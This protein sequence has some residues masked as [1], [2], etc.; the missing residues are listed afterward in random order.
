[1]SLVRW[2]ILRA[3]TSK[4]AQVARD[5]NDQGYRTHLAWT[6]ARKQI[7]HHVITEARLRLSPYVFVAVDHER[8][9]FTPVRDT[10][11]VLDYLATGGS[12]GRAASIPA[13]VIEGIRQ[14]EIEDYEAATRRV[15]RKPTVFKEGDKVKII[16]DMFA[17]KEGKVIDARPGFVIVEL[18]RWPWRI[19]AGDLELIERADGSSVAA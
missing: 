17:G 19:P 7:G 1:M 3:E 12:D 14:D 8:Q 13:A 5:L 4:D 2:H 9:E 11:H 16:R 15:R 10:L 18:N 6:F